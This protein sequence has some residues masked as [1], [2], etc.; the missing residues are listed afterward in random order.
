[1]FSKRSPLPTKQILRLAK[2]DKQGN[3]LRKKML[4]GISPSGLTSPFHSHICHPSPQAEDL[5]FGCDYSDWKNA[6]AIQTQHHLV[7]LL[8]PESLINRPAKL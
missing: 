8:E 2:D 3:N 7:M 1:M 5:F 4:E 6:L